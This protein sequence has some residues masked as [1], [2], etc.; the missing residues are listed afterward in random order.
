[1]KKVF[2]FLYLLLFLSIGI[3]AQTINLEQARELALANS[4]SLAQYEMDIRNSILN[5][6]SQ[7][8]SMLPE[9]SAG[10]SASADFLKNWEFVNP[11]DN[12]SAGANISITQIIFQGG[13][14]FIQKAISEIRT[15]R[16]RINARS[17]YFNVLDEI[18]NAY[19]NVLRAGAALEAI[20]TSLQ[21]A[22]L[23]LSIAEIRFSSGMINQGEYMEALAEKETRENTRNQARRSLTS[24]MNKFKS[25]TGITESVELEQIVFDNY[26]DVISHLA[27]I[28]EE[29]ADV[30]FG[31]LREIIASSNISLSNAAL[32]NLIAEKNFT[33][34]KRDFAPTISATIFSAN[35]NFLPS[36]NAAS[37]GGFSIRG[38]IPLDFWVLIN[39]REQSRIEYQQ[40]INDYENTEIKMEQTLQDALFNLFSQAGAVLSSRRS[41]EYRQRSFDYVMERYRLLQSSI[42]DLSEAARNLIESRNSLNNASYSFLQ[43]LSALRS[44]SA[45]DDEEKL[46][47]LL[48]R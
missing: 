41:L 21:I 39:K 38:T 33:L 43:S 31:N 26:E 27:G 23:G 29:Q 22:V 37:S 3:F 34:S 24:S 36:Y 35:M 7:L 46:L 18:D 14:S 8:Y 40:A 30:L 5:E 45:L 28:S 1:M 12:F 10:Y 16:V 47:E 9:I 20:E 44:L 48:L 4:R 13:R 19:Y 17:E 15:E 25:L 2:I 42:Y 32:S 11:M 6:R